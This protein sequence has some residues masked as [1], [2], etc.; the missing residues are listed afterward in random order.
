MECQPRQKRMLFI[1]GSPEHLMLWQSLGIRP[2][3]QSGVLLERNRS[4]LTWRQRKESAFGRK[5]SLAGQT[6]CIAYPP[7]RFCLCCET[8][9]NFL[10]F[11]EPDIWEL[12]GRCAKIAAEEGAQIL[13]EIHEHFSI[14]QKLAC[15]DYYVY[16]FALPM[17]LLHAIYFKNSEYLKHWFE[18]C[19][20]KQFTTL[21]THDGIGVV[22][23]RGFCQTRRLKLRKSICLSM[24]L[25]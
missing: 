5:S 21:D 16:D 10:L 20:R 3:R 12:L 1:S 17:L 24:A 14:Q 19:P 6:R 8:T 7:G 15:R 22:D 2:R 18:I 11:V 23:V 4:T 25:M 13:P 9:G